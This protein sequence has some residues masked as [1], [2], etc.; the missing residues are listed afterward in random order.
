MSVIRI[1]SKE[2]TSLLLLVQFESNQ[3]SM[4]RIE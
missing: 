1:E 4:N 3:K 2:N